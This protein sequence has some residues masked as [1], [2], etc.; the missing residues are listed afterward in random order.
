MPT[1]KDWGALADA[2]DRYDALADP[3][4]SWHLT[5]T[6][7]ALRVEQ[8]AMV[9]RDLYGAHCVETMTMRPFSRWRMRSPV[10]LVFLLV[11]VNA[12]CNA[13]ISVRHESLG[14]V[15]TSAAFAL[16]CVGGALV[17]WKSLR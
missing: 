1:W 10:P 15:V 14:W 3:Y 16:A 9:A 12:A 6:E 5:P 17:S 13:C 4:R 11:A 8:L 7:R 2:L